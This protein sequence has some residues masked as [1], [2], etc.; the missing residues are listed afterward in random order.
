M[1]V[2]L[3]AGKDTKSRGLLLSIYSNCLYLQDVAGVKVQ[4]YLIEKQDITEGVWVACS[5]YVQDTNYRVIGLEENHRYLF[6]VFSES[7]H[8]ILSVALEMDKSVIITIPFGKTLFFS[9]L[10]KAKQVMMQQG[11]NSC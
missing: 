11:K 8:G 3:I 2:L 5:K 4:N 1:S 6:R 10:E 9:L 7:E